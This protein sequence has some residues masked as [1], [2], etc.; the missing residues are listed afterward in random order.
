M[1]EK[2]ITT[3]KAA[4]I[5]LAFTL[6]FFLLLFTLLPF[7]KSH[8][9]LHPALYWFVTGYFLFIPLFVCALAMARAEGNRGTRQILAALHITPFTKKEWKYSIGGLLLG[10]V[11]TGLVF[12]FSFL[13]NKFLGTAMLNTTPWF[14][15]MRPFRGAEKLLLFVWLPMFFF[16]IVGEEI[17]WRGYIQG[18][19]RGKYSWLLCSLL[20]LLFHLPFGADLMVML[21]PVIIIIPYAFHKTGNT[22]VGMFIHGMYNGP[23]FVAV[24]LGWIK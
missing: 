15:E 2:K 23:M 4:L 20:W 24:A 17:L 7:L 22:L 1:I 14:M 11:L 9:T 18:R 16:N 3:F 8:F 13:L 10:F 12:G 6:Y 21:V 19:M 5:F